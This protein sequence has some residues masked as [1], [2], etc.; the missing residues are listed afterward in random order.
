VDP[1]L[2]ITQVLMNLPQA[3]LSELSDWLPDQ[4]KI[5]PIWSINGVQAL[6]HRSRLHKLSSTMLAI[7]SQMR[8][9]ICVQNGGLALFHVAP[10]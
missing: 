1:Q 10:H 9:R 6:E 8:F 3:K 7:E 5:R 2:Y 4:W